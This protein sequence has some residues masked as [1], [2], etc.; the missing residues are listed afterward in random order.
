MILDPCPSRSVLRALPHE[1][2]DR[3][4][5]EWIC[6]IQRGI[7]TASELEIELK[8]PD[9]VAAMENRLWPL[10]L[11]DAGIPTYMVSIEPAWAELLFEARLA[12]ETL[13]PRELGLG[14]SR[15]HVYYRS[16]AGLSIRSPGR[17]LWYVKGG[18]QG[19]P[20][21]HL[22]AVSQLAEVV[23][24]HPKA[25]YRRFS[26]LGAWSFAQIREAAGTRSEAMA[27][28]VVNTELL[29]TPLSL[30]ELRAVNREAG[31]VF[32]APQ[33]PIAIEEAMFSRLYARSSAYAE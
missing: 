28:R 3:K 15:E 19:H 11:L 17:I 33:A 22:R 24:G 7:L 14:L 16:I 20:E 2:F 1:G 9:E 23:R 27:L 13:F 8:G 18:K 5:A 29:A 26:R 32:H 4:G 25:L 6:K 21:G 30:E 12:G 10:K 31:Q